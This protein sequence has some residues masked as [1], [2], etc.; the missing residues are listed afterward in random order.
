[1]RC[2]VKKNQ[3]SPLLRL[4]PEIR[5]KIWEYSLGSYVF[6]AFDLG[7]RKEKARVKWVYKP[8]IGVALLRTCRQIYSE[9]ASMLI[10][11]NT[12]ATS[13]PRCGSWAL[14]LLPPY[15]R[16][17][18]TTIRYEHFQIRFKQRLIRNA[19]GIAIGQASW[20]SLLAHLRAAKC[21]TKLLP[22]LNKFE[23]HTF[24]KV[25]EYWPT[26]PI[27]RRRIRAVFRKHH[28]SGITVTV[29]EAGRVFPKEYG[30]GS[31]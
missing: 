10:P 16:R 23:I 6:R 17:Q 29:K 5:N 19:F 27:R 28:S 25:M 1:M 2:R 22:N 21:Q 8:G 3:D 9:A 15:Q 26:N 13:D 7:H 18:I 11:L 12:F 30:F 4:P 20:H 24:N 31:E 14:K